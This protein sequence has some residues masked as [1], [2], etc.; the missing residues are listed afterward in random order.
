MK[1]S[2]EFYLWRSVQSVSSA[3]RFSIL[4]IPAILAI[5]AFLSLA[6]PGQEAPG[7]FNAGQGQGTFLILSDI[8]FDPFA[9]PAIVPK[10]A[11]SKVEDWESIFRSSSVQAF[12]QYGS[13]SN[14]PLLASVLTAAREYAARQRYDYVVFA[15]DYLVHRFREKYRQQVGGNEEAYRQFV[16][17]TMTFVSRMIQQS[18]PTLPVFGTLGNNDSVCGDY[19]L[20]P[21]GSFLASV[22][23]EWKVLA[24]DRAAMNDFATG[25]F[26]MVPH[27]SVPSQELIVLNS[28]FWSASYQDACGSTPGDPGAA[29]LNWLAWKLYQVRVAKKTATLI[30]HIPPGIDAFYS[31]RS[32][33]CGTVTTL[34]KPAYVSAFL[35]T[36]EMYKDV[37]RD[38]YA[39]HM[40]MDDFRLISDSSGAPFLETHV[41]PAISPVYGN[42]PAFE[43][44]LYA[45]SNGQLTDYAVVYLA[46]LADFKEGAQKKPVWPV[47]YSVDSGYRIAEYGPQGA[48]K[49]AD[50]IRSDP[51]TR[52]QYMKFY[53]VKSS[54]TPSVNDDNW[55]IYACAQTQITADAFA[56][57]SCPSSG[58]H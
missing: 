24:S 53:A 17:K 11:A 54:K 27:P 37:L 20:S 39:G 22:A 18:F 56:K 3:A 8:H 25:G 47:E 40:H 21:G 29:E 19:R 1:A 5:S 49:I 48:K 4:A 41:V 43:I 42:N 15:G 50:A 46:N 13:D 7:V 55:L 14:Y 16:A 9:D 28:T 12:S 34:W 23:K 58:A 33:K 30:M 26:Y 38:N 52:A 57:C 2:L 31:A 6:A 45:K 10:L 44:G 35:Q 51:K 36:I 32:G